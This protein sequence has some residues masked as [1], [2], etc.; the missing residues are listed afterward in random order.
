MI[1]AAEVKPGDRVLEIGAGSGYAAAVLG[2]IA[3]QVYTIERHGGLARSAKDRLARLGYRNIEVR[4][5]DGTLGWPEA[6]PFDAII[7]TAGGPE[8]PESLRNQLTIGG[9]LV[10]PIGSSRESQ[11]LIRVIRTEDAY[12]QEEHGACA[13]V[14]LI[15]RYGWTQR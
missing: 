14:P 11:R 2:R 10:I 1:E 5:G 13:F 4:C 6:A 12:E 8:I 7:V 9:R 3:A 15:G